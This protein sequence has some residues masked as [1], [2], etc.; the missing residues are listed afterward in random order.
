MSLKCKMPILPVQRAVTR[1]EW[2]AYY[3]AVAR[4]QALERAEKEAALRKPPPTWQCKPVSNKPF[5][6]HYSTT[7]LHESF[8]KN[9]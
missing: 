6:N 1:D 5:Y 3:E 4:A 7:P 2:K 8:L 9:M